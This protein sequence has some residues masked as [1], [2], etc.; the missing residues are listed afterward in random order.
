MS[1]DIG[2]DR[3]RPASPKLVEHS[4]GRAELTRCAIAALQRVVIDEG[5]LQI[6]QVVAVGKALD[7]GHVVLVDSHRQGEARVDTSTVTSR[8]SPLTTT[9]IVLLFEDTCCIR[10][11]V[12]S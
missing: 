1:G 3:R 12:H 8:R 6:A 9:L 7:G 2:A 10:S 5:P 4:Y 11:L